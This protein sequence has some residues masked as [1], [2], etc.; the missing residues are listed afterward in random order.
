MEAIQVIY[1]LN[2]ENALREIAGLQE[3]METYKIPKGT[4]IV[5]EDRYKEQLPDKISMV[6]ASEWLTN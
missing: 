2:K 5:F 6:S 3:S 4:L 1:S